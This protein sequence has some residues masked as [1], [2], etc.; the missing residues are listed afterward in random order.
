MREGEGR[1]KGPDLRSK[2]LNN[3][4]GKQTRKTEESRAEDR[5]NHV[6]VFTTV[7]GRRTGKTNQGN[8]QD[9]DQDRF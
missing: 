4:N 7:F 5:G 8:P 9:S 1:R 3:E 2:H 6:H